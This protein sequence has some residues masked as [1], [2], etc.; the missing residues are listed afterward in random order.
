MISFKVYSCYE[1]IGLKFYI[2]YTKIGGW[3]WSLLISL[4]I[5]PFLFVL[6]F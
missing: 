3:F 2:D 1:Y 4:L 5:I 6:L